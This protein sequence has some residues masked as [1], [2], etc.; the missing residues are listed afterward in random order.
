MYYG[1]TVRARY[2]AVLQYPLSPSSGGA[3]NF[4]QEEKT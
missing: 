4:E 1:G 2:P 3:A